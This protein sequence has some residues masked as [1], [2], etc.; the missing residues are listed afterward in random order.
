MEYKGLQVTLTKRKDETSEEKKERKKA[1]EFYRRLRR[2]DK[3]MSKGACS[4]KGNKDKQWGKSV[5]KRK[6]KHR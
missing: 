3:K 1:V 4:K 2:M 5:K 6:N